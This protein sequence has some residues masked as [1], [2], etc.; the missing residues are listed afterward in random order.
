[1]AMYVLRGEYPVFMPG[2]GYMGAI[3]A[4]AT[5]ALSWLAGSS[6][7]VLYV[8]PMGL[9]VGLVALIHLLG[10]RL[11][12]SEGGL[13]AGAFAAFQ[14]AFLVVFG[15]SPRLGYIET[16]VWGALLLLLAERLILKSGMVR[17]RALFLV[18]GFVSGL[19]F[20][21]N[22]LV[23]PFILTV[24]LIL[25]IHRGRSLLRSSP[26]AAVAG[27]LIGSVPFWFFN[28]QSGFWSFALLD[29]GPKGEVLTRIR[30]FLEDV[31]PFVLGMRDIS[32]GGW[33]WLGI[34]FSGSGYAAVAG[35]ALVSWLLR[36]RGRVALVRER[37]FLFPAGVLLFTV[38]AFV[39]SRY[40]HLG[41]PRYVFPFYVGLPLLLA[42]AVT[43][44]W[45]RSRW[46][47]LAAIPI[48][49]G[50]LSGVAKAYQDFNLPKWEA[51]DVPK[52]EP[53]LESL[54]REGTERIYADY[55]VSVRMNYESGESMVSSDFGD[56]RYRPYTE[57]VGEAGKVAVVTYGRFSALGLSQDAVTAS[58]RAVGL[59]FRES[60]VAGWRIYD[61]FR[62]TA[63]FSAGIKPGLWQAQS[64]ETRDDPRLAFDRDVTTRWGSGKPRQDGIWY[65]L[66]LG[67]IEMVRRVVLLP[68]I[69]MTDHPVGLRIEAS[70]DKGAWKTVWELG[71]IMPGLHVR[72]GQPRFDASGGVEA[73]FAPIRAR[74]LRFTHLGIG[75][76]FDWSIG[77]IFVFSPADEDGGRDAS[78]NLV[79]AR[80]D[81]SLGRTEKGIE[82][83][84]C[85]LALDPENAEAHR[86]KSMIAADVRP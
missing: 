54:G 67:K 50:N 34:A 20:W 72:G 73:V 10:R 60:S 49:V 30:I 1:M 85:V 65:L 32:T 35:I 53:V 6:P 58:L 27:F 69:F 5:A 44:V 18:L 66:D 14:P 56:D 59:E 9:S 51:V 31:L 55:G 36:G 26:A 16:L 63:P 43:L 77:E 80:R 12:G 62:R 39:A 37:A 61:R 42:G 57:I 2:L 84:S 19:A 76:P 81:L 46:W 4:Y 70:P 13:W 21:T 7:Q 64:S 29:S 52:L 22:L 40:G 17:E 38:L 15:N 41:S 86:L 24:L 71:E 45:R 8:V 25:L 79:K 83:L 47:G 11:L 33:S 23:A 82:R 74:Y 28:V 68:G 3:E 75:P 48:L 78:Q